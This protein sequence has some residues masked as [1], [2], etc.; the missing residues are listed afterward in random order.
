MKIDEI[1]LARRED[2]N[3]VDQLFIN[4]KTE[5]LNKNIFQWDDSYPNRSYVEESIEEEELFIL[6]RNEKV[7]GAVVLNEWQSS[8]WEVIP[9]QHQDGMYLIIHAFCIDPM[10]QGQGLAKLFLQFWEQYAKEHGYNGIRLDAF[11][12]NAV[13]LRFYETNGYIKR[14]EVEFPFK[15]KGHQTYY[16][17]EKVMK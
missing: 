16:C 14:G 13:A 7:I 8:E 5:L 9:W 11:S 6:K 2:V 1:V 10:Y 12:G 3:S 15:P 17:Y 4:C